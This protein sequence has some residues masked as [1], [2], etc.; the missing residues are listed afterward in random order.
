MC[1]LNGVYMPKY[2]ENKYYMLGRLKMVL[3]KM[4]LRFKLVNCPEDIRALVFK[5]C[6]YALRDAI[7]YMNINI[8]QFYEYI[9]Q[10]KIY[11]EKLFLQN[12]LSGFYQSWNDEA[13]YYNICCNI[14]NQHIEISSFEVIASYF[15]KEGKYIDY[16][17]GTGS[18]SLGLLLQNKLKGTL[19][20]LDMPNDINK[21]I[22]YRIKKNNLRKFARFS[23]VLNYF[24]PDS[25]DGIICVDVLEHLEN[26]SEI[27]INKIHPLL[28]IGGLIYLRAPWRGQLTH[29]DQAADDFYFNGGRKFLYRKY[30]EIY[31]TSSMDISCVY[32]KVRR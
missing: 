23:N 21:F 5:S 32:K 15:T 22:E 24:E 28:K 27:F 3:Q 19:L 16:G 20:L 6:S 25:A 26:S 11:E 8:N 14:I 17:C 1:L 29:I 9:N 7:E 10:W 13:A 12:D 31:R 30:R 2:P 18:L 4:K